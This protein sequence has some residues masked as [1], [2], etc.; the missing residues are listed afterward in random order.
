[1]ANFIGQGYLFG[2]AT[3]TSTISSLSLYTSP[4]F[5]TLSLTHAS[6][7]TEEMGQAG[8]IDALIGNSRGVICTFRFKPRGSTLTAARYGANLPQV[9]AGVNIVNL[10]V[11]A[12]GGFTDVFN[13]SGGG[14]T[15]PWIYDGGGSIEGVNDNVWTGVMTLRRYIDITSAT[16]IT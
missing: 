6:D 3:I 9:C 15:Q 10:P 11:I 1:M 4:K 7:F 8:S 5:E 2:L 16:L 14:N 12:F 13:T